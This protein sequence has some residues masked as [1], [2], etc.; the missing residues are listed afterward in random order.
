[1]KK[2]GR[3]KG[4][5][6]PSFVIDQERP[7]KLLVCAEVKKRKSCAVGGRLKNKRKGGKRVSV[8]PARDCVKNRKGGGGAHG[9]E[10]KAAK[11]FLEPRASL[12]H[13]KKKYFG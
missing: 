8:G 5:R 11:R 4:E 6:K 12:L 9:D 2:E 7:K 1:M 3:G 13:G 10:K